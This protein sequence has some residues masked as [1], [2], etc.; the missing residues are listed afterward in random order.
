MCLLER[1]IMPRRLRD[2]WYSTFPPAVTLKRFFAP[3]LVLSLGI[4]L[5]FAAAGMENGPAGFGLSE[6]AESPQARQP[7]RPGGGRAALW[8]RPPRNTTKT[9]IYRP[10]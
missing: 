6:R 2:C 9:R 1:L 3:D 5:S 8:Q 7:F 4:W 10:K